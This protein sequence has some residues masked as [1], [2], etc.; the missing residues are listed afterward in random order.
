M[1]VHSLSNLSSRCAALHYIVFETP[2]SNHFR[3]RLSV[4]CS[5]RG[6]HAQPNNCGASVS[7]PKVDARMNLAMYL[8]GN[9]GTNLRV[10]FPSFLFCYQVQRRIE[11]SCRN[12]SVTATRSNRSLLV[13]NCCLQFPSAVPLVIAVVHKIRSSSERTLKKSPSCNAN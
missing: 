7:S 13:A 4:R 10:P 3:W 5:C 12:G 11:G 2:E 8:E 1:V 9:G 6:C